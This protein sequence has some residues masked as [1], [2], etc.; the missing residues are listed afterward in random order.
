MPHFHFGPDF[1]FWPLYTTIQQ[2]YPLGLTV[3]EYDDAFRHRYPGHEQLWDICTDCIENYPAFRQ[4]WKPFQDHLKAVF[5]RTVHHS[6]GPIPSYAGHIVVQK[7]KGPIWGHWKELYFAISLL[8]PYY[9]IYG[10]DTS[11]IELSE[12]RHAM[13]HQ[14]PITQ[15]IGRS[16][17]HA[18]TVSP[19]EEYATLFVSLETAIR[20]WFPEHRL[21]PLKIGRQALTG[22]VVEGCTVQ[23][24]CLHAALFHTEIPWQSLSSQH[25]RGNEY[26]GYEAW[27][28]GPAA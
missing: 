5:K 20:E 8:G 15:P 14:E 16:A 21:V 1:N 24:A 4:R 10:L 26:Y 6:Q 13:G 22:L 3:P 28:A 27:R 18:L 2:Y 11:Q 25:Y 23:P 17:I 9:T 12:T 7:P 19:Y